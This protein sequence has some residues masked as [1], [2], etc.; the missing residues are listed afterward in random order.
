MQL[1][2]F[3]DEN[4][5]SKRIPGFEGLRAILDEL[6]IDENREMLPLK[7]Y[8]EDIEKMRLSL[9][10]VEFM[11]SYPLPTDRSTIAHVKQTL[12][13]LNARFDWDKHYWSKFIRLQM[14]LRAIGK[15]TGLLPEVL[16]LIADLLCPNYLLRPFRVISFR[17]FSA[18]LSSSPGRVGSERHTIS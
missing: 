15:A 13:S 12:H 18:R 11:E 1:A 14:Y 7:I 10:L 5:V 4:G 16:G 17:L 6:S 2:S 9:C 8:K 3:T